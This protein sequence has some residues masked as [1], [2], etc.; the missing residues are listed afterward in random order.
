[1]IVA[2]SVVVRD[3]LFAIKNAKDVIRDGVVL[4]PVPVLLLVV[5]VGALELLGLPVTQERSQAARA[6]NMQKTVT[7]LR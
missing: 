7:G 6:S 2:V 4:P 1:V 5:L 3:G